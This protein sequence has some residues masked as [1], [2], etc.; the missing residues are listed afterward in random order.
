MIEERTW[1]TKYRPKKLDEI[2]GNKPI[3]ASIKAMMPNITHMILQGPPGVGKTTIA[4]A[5]VNELGCTWKEINASDESSINVVRTTI[6]NFMNTGSLDK[7]PKV[8]I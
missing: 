8:L 5:I 7:K 4:H 6:K 3:I 1:T 2:A